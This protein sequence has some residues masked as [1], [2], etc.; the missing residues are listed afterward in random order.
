MKSINA[1][2]TAVEVRTACRSGQWTLPT[3][4]LALGYVQ[5]N[6]VVLPKEYAFDF[7]LFC[8]RNA[9]PCP[10]LAVT[11]PGQT[12]AAEVAPGSDLRT[13][14]PRYA[15]YQDG[16]LIDMPINLHQYWRD[17]FV[18]FLLGCS[19]TFEAAMLSAGLP[20][21]HIDQKVNVPMYRTNRPNRKAGIFGGDLVVSMRPLKPEMVELASRLSADMPLAHGA[22]VHIGSPQELGISDLAKPDFGDVVTI[23]AD[24]IPVFWACGVTPQAAIMAAK[25]TL[26]LTHLPGH[27]FLTDLRDQ[28]LCAHK[29]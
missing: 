24:E 4:G 9:Q 22:P 6:L 14:V 16:T 20:V 13:D 26:A 19:F 5:A 7:L 27:M 18:S 28:D 21:R 17:D 23:H 10:L 12:E 2:S 25:P 11:E 1:S 3:S 8:Q 15:V 29:F